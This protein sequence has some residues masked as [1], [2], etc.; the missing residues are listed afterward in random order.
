MAFRKYSGGPEKSKI[1]GGDHSPQ[2]VA[3]LFRQSP[4]RLASNHLAVFGV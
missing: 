2:P 4:C 3:M 1:S